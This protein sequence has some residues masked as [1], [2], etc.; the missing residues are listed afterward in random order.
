MARQFD[1][2]TK[3]IFRS[4]EDTAYIRFGSMRDKDPQ[5]NIRNGQLTLSGY[6]LELAV[7]DTLIYY[8]HSAEVASIFKPS[9]EATKE[10]INR[11][12]N[13]TAD[14][15]SVRTPDARAGYLMMLT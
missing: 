2:T 11:Q 6:V 10:G 7:A 9:I 14:S 4:P 5:Y 3:T 15:I 12:C 8:N 13:D 1:K